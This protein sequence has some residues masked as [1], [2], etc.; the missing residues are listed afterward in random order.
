MAVGLYLLL[1][2]KSKD[3]DELKKKKKKKKNDN[4][5]AAIVAPLLAGQ[6]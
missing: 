4:K 2:A 1:W 5:D 6:P 3:Y